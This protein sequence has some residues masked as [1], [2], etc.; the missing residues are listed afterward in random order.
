MN[1]SLGRARE[2]LISAGDDGTILIQVSVTQC[3]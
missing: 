2:K 3:H 1:Q